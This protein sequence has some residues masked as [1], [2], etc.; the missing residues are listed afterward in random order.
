MY[1]GNIHICICGGGSLGHVCA[2][3]IASKGGSVNILSG[4][5]DKWGAVAEATDPEG[6]VF[7][8]N[9][10]KVSSNPAEVAKDQDIIL[11]CV[12][13]YLIEKTLQDIKPYVGKAA[14]GTVVSSTGFFFFAHRILG[15]EARLF[16]FQRVPYIARVKEY[17]KSA[18]LLGYK[19]SLLAAVEN[20]QDKESFAKT[21]QE[22]FL[23]PVALADNYYQVSLTNSNP[24][25]HTGR[26]YSMFH[27]RETHVFPKNILFYQEWTDD[28]SETLIGMDK[29]FFTLLDKLGVTGI[30]TLLDYYDS[31]DAA[32]L[33]RKLSSIPAFQGITSPM[34]E[35]P[36]G[37]VADFGSRYFTEDFPFGLRWIKELAIQNNIS[38]PVIDKVYDW[39]MNLL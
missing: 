20:I 15:P 36:G 13:G 21:L 10:S 35:V 14:V 34:K 33:T 12:P 32:S 25:L 30:P 5:P 31:T 37:W 22:L 6:K 16:G 17:G 23:T 1:G 28:A 9:L 29:E 18:N 38:T 27:G 4:H 26:L 11:L 39:G 8:G 19:S 2:A 7:K 3:V 24:I